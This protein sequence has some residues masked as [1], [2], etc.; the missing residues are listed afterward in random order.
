MMF[1]LQC[2]KCKNRMKYSS[3]GLIS[4]KNKKRCVYCGKSFSVR[5]NTIQKI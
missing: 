5:Q 3:A 1:L 2:P 4:E